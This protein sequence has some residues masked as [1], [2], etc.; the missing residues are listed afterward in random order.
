[1]CV[2][3]AFVSVL[4]DPLNKLVEFL[5]VFLQSLSI[6]DGLKSLLCITGDHELLILHQLNQVLKDVEIA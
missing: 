6:K 5:L 3:G 1:M 4:V 2:D